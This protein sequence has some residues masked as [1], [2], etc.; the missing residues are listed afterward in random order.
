MIIFHRIE[1]LKRHLSILKGKGLLIGFV[2]TM[3]AL[4][5]GHLSLIR[6]CRSAADVTVCSIF[7]NPTQFN[8]KADFDKYPITTSKDIQLLIKEDTDILFLPSVDEIYPNGISSN[9]YYDLG[10]LETI[11]EGAHRPGHFQGVCQVVHRLLD[12]VEPDRMFLGQ[13]DYQQC[14]VLKKLIELINVPTEIIIANTVRESSGL[15]MSSRNLRLSEEEKQKATAIYTTL[16]NI[17]NS[18]PSKSLSDIKKES[19]TTLL[20]NGFNKI[21][22]ITIADANTLHPISNNA[23]LTEEKQLVALIAAFMGEVRLIDNMILN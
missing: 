2:P 12:I 6:N 3:G 21:D 1:G 22:Y 20:N 18:I 17:Q 19:T 4:H 5:E 23:E 14:M 11:L 7:V 8:D 9:Q 13:K 16:L 10:Y 15:A